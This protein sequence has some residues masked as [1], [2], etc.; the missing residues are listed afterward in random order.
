MTWKNRDGEE[1]KMNRIIKEEEEEEKINKKQKTKKTTQV[2]EEAT[3]RRST[4]VILQEILKL[5][6]ES[7]RHESSKLK[8]DMFLQSFAFD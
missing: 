8:N 3:E 1:N 4:G 2:K 7:C 6:I 5:L